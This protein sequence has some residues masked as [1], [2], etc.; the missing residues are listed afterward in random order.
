[1][2]EP[3]AW[4]RYCDGSYE[5]PIMDNLIEDVRKKSGAWTPLFAK[6]DAETARL[7]ADARF[8]E[9]TTPNCWCEKCRPITLEDMRMVLCPECGNKR[10]PRATDHNNDC[11]NS[12]EPGQP[13][14]SYPARRLTDALTEEIARLHELL[15]QIVR[16]HDEAMRAAVG[17]EANYHQMRRNQVL[18]H[19]TPNAQEARKETK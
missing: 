2:S 17:D 11:T 4:I 1:M 6:R 15:Q 18:F 9:E 3:V 14:N 19:L 7:R 16:H 13:G 5:G 8:R 12:N 10:C